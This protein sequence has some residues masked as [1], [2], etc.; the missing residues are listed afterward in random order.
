MFVCAL[1][2]RGQQPMLRPLF[3]HSMSS[4]LTTVLLDQIHCVQMNRTISRAPFLSSS[5][6]LRLLM[7]AVSLQ[8][9]ELSLSLSVSLFPSLCFYSLSYLICVCPC[10]VYMYKCFPDN[11]FVNCA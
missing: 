6:S 7:A 9:C 11:I 5:F 1:L 2:L 3:V 10:T 4:V 8:L